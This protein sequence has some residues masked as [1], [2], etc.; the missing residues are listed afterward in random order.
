M[1]ESNVEVAAMVW[2]QLSRLKASIIAHVNKPEIPALPAASSCEPVNKK[3][4]QQQ[5]FFSTKRKQLK[6]KPELALAKPGQKEK[7]LTQSTL[8]GRVVAVSQSVA[9]TDHHYEAS[10]CDLI[11]LNHSY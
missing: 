8:D 10:A 1:A 2:E 7:K 4:T 9:S 6:R 3:V 5:R 11:K